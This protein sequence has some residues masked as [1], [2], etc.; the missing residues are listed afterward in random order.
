[1]TPLPSRTTTVRG[2]VIFL[3]L[4]FCLFCG[5]LSPSNQSIVEVDILEK[6]MSETDLGEC[7]Y[8]TTMRVT[9]N[10]TVDIRALSVLVELYDPGVQKVAARETVPIGELRSGEIKNATSRLQTHCRMNYTLRAYA[11]Y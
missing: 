2:M 10:G 6:N 9:N 11:R 7:T 3:S 4:A 1:M 8:Q 5:C